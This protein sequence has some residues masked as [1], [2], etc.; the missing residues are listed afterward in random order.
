MP[1]VPDPETAPQLEPRTT[2]GESG[3]YCP[4][5]R[6]N[7]PSNGLQPPGWILYYGCMNPVT[8]TEDR[9]MKRIAIIAGILIGAAVAF[10]LCGGFN[11]PTVDAENADTVSSI[12]AS[13]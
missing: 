4:H 9:P 1:T 10:A 8:L 7:F 11:A 2:R 12:L 13:M 5:N 3:A 6:T